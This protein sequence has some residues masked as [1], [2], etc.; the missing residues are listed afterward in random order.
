[1]CYTKCDEAKGERVIK[2]NALFRDAETRIKLK[3][4]E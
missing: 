2:V 1:L 4:G 3:G